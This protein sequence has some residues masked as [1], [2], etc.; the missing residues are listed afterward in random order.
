MG[1]KKFTLNGSIFFKQLHRAIQVYMCRFCVSLERKGA[2][3]VILIHFVSFINC[4]AASALRISTTVEFYVN[5]SFISTG[6]AGF[7]F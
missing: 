1:R 2:A 5:L 4:G 6:K 7:V 3:T